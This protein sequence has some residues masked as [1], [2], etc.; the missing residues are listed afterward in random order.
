MALNFE[1]PDRTPVFASFVP[2]IEERL[3]TAFNI[4]D[5]DVGVALGNDMVKCCA[6]MEM[7]FYGHPEP[8]YVDA[9]GIRWRYVKNDSGVYTEIAEH[10]LA[11]DMA[12]LDSLEIPDPL[13]DSQ[14]EDFRLKK[15]CTAMKNG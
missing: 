11:G 12:K 6:G 10:P 13:E 15:K 9:W 3:R 7:S 2:E 4:S 1:A 5:A 14:Y 8:E